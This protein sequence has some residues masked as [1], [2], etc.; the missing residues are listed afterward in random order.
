MKSLKLTTALALLLVPAAALHAQAF[1]KGTTAI[2][3]GIGVGGA[4]YSY[5]SAYNSDYK[6]SPTIIASAE[7]GVASVDG[8]GAIGIGGL[9]ANKS[10]RYQ[11]ASQGSY[12][13]YDYD[14]KWSNTVIGLRGTIHLNELLESDKFD[15]YGG[16]MLGYNIGSYKD[17]S[18]RTIN[19]VT[20]DYSDNY[21]YKL[22]FVTWS[23]FIGGRYL[24][25]DHLGAYLEVGYGASYLNLGLTAKF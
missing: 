7:H 25:T 24:F 21:H 6:T 11:A 14:R 5:I 4:R 9:F 15:V 1:D 23:T 19:G 13:R 12:Y 17:K 22:N 3:L 20:E 16:V 8:I 10:V 18:T 2:N